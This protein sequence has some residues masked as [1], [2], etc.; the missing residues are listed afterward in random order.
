MAK[1]LENYYFVWFIFLKSTVQMWC[2]HYTAAHRG[3]LDMRNMEL[4]SY[5]ATY[6]PVGTLQLSGRTGQL[7]VQGLSQSGL[8]GMLCPIKVAGGE[9]GK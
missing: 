9:S 1:V 5:S 7:Q 6:S 4:V 8:W 3:D 2:L